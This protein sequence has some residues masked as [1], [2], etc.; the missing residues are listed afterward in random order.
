[1]NS[2]LDRLVERVPVRTGLGLAGTIRLLDPV[3]L[4]R[5]LWSRRELIFQLTK[6]DILGRYRG[7]YLGLA[8]SFLTP[9][10]MLAVFTLVFG[11]IFQRRW[12]L[13]SEGR[14]DFALILFSG[15][16]IFNLFAECMTRAPH[17]ILTQPQYVKK[18][19]FPLEV[20]PVTTLLSAA[21]HA[22]VSFFILFVGL[23]MSSG[24]LPWT[25]VFLPLVLLPLLMLCLGIGW[26][27]A[28]LGVFFRDISQ[29]VG[30]VTTATLFLSP[31]FYPVTVVP[32]WLRP[33]YRLN[34]L[35]SI[36]EN[37][38]AVVVFGRYPDWR[39]VLPLT[40]LT[41][42]AALFSYAWFQRTRKG[43]ADV[44]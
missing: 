41:F 11:V 37:T 8:W 29:L 26:F 39:H 27:L 31:I 28:S 43:F 7:S 25:V 1:M 44:L 30:V 18:V 35:T 23:W 4:L 2:L 9:L 13:E 17:L 3:A 24:P 6:R 15:L 12:G 5:G 32:V 19:V 21:V 42:L 22:A 40:V 14:L 36:I 20:L 33:L 34:P 16:I 38:R 10:L